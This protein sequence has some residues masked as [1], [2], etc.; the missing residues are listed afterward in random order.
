MRIS[1]FE[2]KERDLIECKEVP[3]WF[4]HPFI[5]DLLVN[6]KDNYVMKKTDEGWTRVDPGSSNDYL[7]ISRLPIHILKLETFL[8]RP[9]C[10]GDKVL[11][12]N[13]IDGIRGHND[14]D[15]LEWVSASG[16][17]VHA[18]ET[19]LRDDNIT[20]T[21]VDLVTGDS[22]RFYSL[23]ATARHLGVNAG[24]ITFYL[25]QKRNYPFLWK[26][27]LIAEGKEPN[28]LTEADIGKPAPNWPK[29]FRLRNVETGEVQDFPN[30]TAAGSRLGVSRDTIRRY[31]DAGKLIKGLWEYIPVEDPEELVRISLLAERTVEHKAILFKNLHGKKRSIPVEVSKDGVTVR[32]SSMKE[33]ADSISARANTIQKFIWKNPDKSWNGYSI[34][35]V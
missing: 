31:T 22:I 25:R 29:P 18:Y 32:Y 24:K 19:G 21:L 33:F 34:R 35:Y 1:E 20:V 15:N 7:Y 10:E 13:H 23:Q 28:G 12:G 11:F 8:E 30:N 14:I 2:R 26:Y 17:I 9:I 27:D 6:R 4:Y 5:G 3:G 16:N